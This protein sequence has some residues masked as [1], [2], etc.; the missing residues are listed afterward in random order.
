MLRQ[1]IARSCASERSL[2]ELER[3]LR[4]TFVTLEKCLAISINWHKSEPFTVFTIQFSLFLRSCENLITEKN[5]RKTPRSKMGWKIYIFIGPFLFIAAGLEQIIVISHILEAEIN[6]ELC[7]IFL[8]LKADFLLNN[9]CGRDNSV[10][11]VWGRKSC[12]HRLV[13]EGDVKRVFYWVP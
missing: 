3:S 1:E 4:V 8:G 6:A 11:C 12:C 5:E 13:S 10:S 7:E 2:L 9:K